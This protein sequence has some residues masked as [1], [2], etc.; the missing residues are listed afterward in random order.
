MDPLV[1]QPERLGDF[2]KRCAGRMEAPEG[3]LIPDLGLVGL[4]LMVERAVP[5][6]TGL[7]EEFSVE[8]HVSTMVDRPTMVKL[9]DLSGRLLSSSPGS[10]QAERPYGR[11]AGHALVL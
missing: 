10:W 8:C 2:S 6:L 3:V 9:S 1:A 5:R 7:P 11:P 4:V